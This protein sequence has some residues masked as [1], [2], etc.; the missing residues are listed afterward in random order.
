MHIGMFVQTI[1][2]LIPDFS[3]PSDSGADTSSREEMSQARQSCLGLV[4]GTSDWPYFPDEC[5]SEA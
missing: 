4:P 2:S 3:V 1:I 5:V